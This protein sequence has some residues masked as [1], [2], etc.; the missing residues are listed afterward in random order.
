MQWKMISYLNSN[1][2][3][4]SS[5]QLVAGASSVSVIPPNTAHLHEHT[6]GHIRSHTHTHARADHL[7]Y[8]VPVALL[9]EKQLELCDNLIDF[10]LSSL[11]LSEARRRHFNCTASPQ[12]PNLPLISPRWDRCL[13]AVSGLLLIDVSACFMSFWD[14]TALTQCWFQSAC[15][16][17]PRVTAGES[18]KD[19]KKKKEEG[20]KELVGMSLAQISSGLVSDRGFSSLLMKMF[21][22]HLT[23]HASL[24]DEFNRRKKRNEWWGKEIQLLSDWG[25]KKRGWPLSQR[26]WHCINPFRGEACW[27]SSG[28]RLLQ[29]IWGMAALSISHILCRGEPCM[30][31]I[32]SCPVN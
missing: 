31:W 19:K 30:L 4:H 2:N 15:R 8:S 13:R 3:K 16:I 12:S 23:S 26:F 21:H 28:W 18:K 17:P 32:L 22:S 11:G 10:I 1:H 6:H 29:H 24:T 5:L 14:M 25:G 9:S 7:T 20:K 27:T